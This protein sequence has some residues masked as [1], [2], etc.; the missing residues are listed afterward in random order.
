MIPAAA[1]DGNQ[2]AGTTTY[3]KPAAGELQAQPEEDCGGMDQ[4]VASA[5]PHQPGRRCN[6]KKEVE[7]RQGPEKMHFGMTIGRANPLF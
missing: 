3:G 6:K 7:S 2:A 1:R 5:A 4:A